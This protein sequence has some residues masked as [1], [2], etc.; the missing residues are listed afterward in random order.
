MRY[1][2]L[3]LALLAPAA[4][5]GEYHVL[6]LEYYDFTY[7]KFKANR[8]PYTPDVDNYADR[9]STNF[10]IGLLNN[11]MYWDNQVHT[12]TVDT[13]SVKTVGWH[14]VLGL[15]VTSQIDLFSEHHSR[16][17][18]EEYR[19]TKNGHNTFPVEDSYGIKI[20]LVDDPRRNTISGWFK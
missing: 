3:M 7:Q 9:A 18:M 5:A 15:R 17:V 20:K 6:N 8:D 13:G 4:Y 2:V 11:L 10:R 19:P 16:H 12:E 14:W 1:L